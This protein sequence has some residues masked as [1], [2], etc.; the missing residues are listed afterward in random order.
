MDACR[1]VATWAPRTGIRRCAPGSAPRPTSRTTTRRVAL[2][3]LGFGTA[4]AVPKQGIF[5]GTASVLNLSDAGVR[6]RVLRP[7]L[8]S[9]SA[10]SAPSARRH[11]PQLGHGHRRPHEADLHGRRVVHPRAG[12]LREPAAA[13]SCR[14]KPARRSP[15]WDQVVQGRQPV[16]FQTDSEEE[17]LRAH[18]LATEYKLTPWFRGSGRST[19][20]WTCSRGARSRSSSPQLPRRAQRVE[21]G[22]RAERLAR[23]LRHWYLA[24]TNPAQLANAG[25][26]FAIT[27]DGLSSLNAVPPQPAHRRLA[28]PRGR[29]GARGAHHRARRRGSA[30]SARTAPSPWARWPTSWSPTATSSPKSRACVTCGCRARRYGVTRPPQIDPRG[31]WTHRLAGAGRLQRPRCASRARSTAFAARSSPTIRRAIPLGAARVIAETGRLEVTFPASSWARRHRAARRLRARRRV[32]R[33]DVAPQRDRS[34][35]PRARAPSRSRAPRAARSPSVPQ[36][37]LPFMRP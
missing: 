25:V 15:R 24:P 14:P 17:Y 36:I 4:L 9:P 21:P 27:S 6:E 34:V 32:L 16:L 23:Q 30:S 13:P 7:D 26:P 37:D 18:K 12:R 22:A 3:S 33:L 2:R 20:S 29:Q 19:A 10:S 1:R 35:V 5:R 8:R 11:V 28:R 31:T